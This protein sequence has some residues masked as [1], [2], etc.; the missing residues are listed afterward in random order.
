[1]SQPFQR[2]VYYKGDTNENN[3]N[4]DDSKSENDCLVRKLDKEQDYK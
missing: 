2:K 1:M 4:I 3:R